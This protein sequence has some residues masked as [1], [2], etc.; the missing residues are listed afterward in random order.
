MGGPSSH[1]PSPTVRVVGLRAQGEHLAPPAPGAPFCIQKAGPPSRLPQAL[2]CPPAAVPGSSALPWAAATSSSPART[3]K[4]G[5]IFQAPAARWPRPCGTGRA[6]MSGAG[7]AAP[8]HTLP[9]PGRDP[10]AGSRRLV[11]GV[12]WS[13]GAESPGHAENGCA[14]R[15]GRARR[16]LGKVKPLPALKSLDGS[17]WRTGGGT[18]AGC[19]E[20]DPSSQPQR[21]QSAG[22]G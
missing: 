11:P 22:R 12:P 7:Q 21:G 5:R 2:F 9:G 20:P 1:Q 6:G 10:P 16:A 14:W 3:C 13:R 17:G 4:S 15:G 18:P 8:C 19:R